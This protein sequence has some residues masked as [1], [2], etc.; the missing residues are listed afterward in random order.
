MAE[1]ERLREGDPGDD[2]TQKSCT[3]WLLISCVVLTLTTAFVFGWGLGAPNMYTRYTEP[4]LKKSDPCQVEA[5]ARANQNQTTPA[6]VAPVPPTIVNIENNENN[7]NNE[8]AADEDEEGNIVGRLDEDGNEI[9]EV[10]EQPQS[11]QSAPPKQTFHFVQELIKGIPQTVFLI[12]AFIGA[13]TGPFWSALFDRKRT[14]FANYIF[15]FSSSLCILLAYYFVQP[16]LFYLS[17][18]LLGY[19]GR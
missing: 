9:D 12:G 15:C 1:V 4:F 7:E 2:S 16:W 6:P 5:E 10:E 17:R 13:I 8:K 19:Q 11:S 14:V 18:L 3:S